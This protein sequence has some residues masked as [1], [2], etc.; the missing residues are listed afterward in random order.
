[1]FSFF[2]RKKSANVTETVFTTTRQGLTIRGTE[3][4]PEG[5]RLPAAI[6]C[7]GFMATQGTVR[8]YANALAE[9]GYATYIF[10]FCGGSAAFGKSEG[11]TTD[12]SVL[13]E[14]ADLEAVIA[15]VTA[16]PY[17]DASRLLLAGCSQGGFVSALTAAKHPDLAKRLVLIFPALC[18]PE[19]W[20]ERYATDEEIPQS[21]EFWGLT[22]GKGFVTSLRGMDVFAKMPEYSKPVIIFQGAKDPIATLGHSQRAAGGHLIGI[23]ALHY[24]RAHFP[25]LCLQQADGV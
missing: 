15:E 4:R 6:M 11:K 13:T 5:D 14:V 7:H 2:R 20:T 18:I 8:Q 21:I 24:K 17:V 10:D 22:L 25:H 1:M 3:L 16:R 9:A 19:N 12:M 23:G